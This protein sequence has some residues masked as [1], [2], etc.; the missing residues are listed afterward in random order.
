MYAC[1]VYFN[2]KAEGIVGMENSTLQLTIAFLSVFIF[3]IIKQGFHF[4]IL[5]TDIA[6]LVFLGLFIT[7]IGC[8]LYFSSIGSIKI[9]TV[10]ILG[11]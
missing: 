9:Q 1:M 4:N 5:Q 10:A 8:F 2:K 7:G 11:Y 6:P 3:V